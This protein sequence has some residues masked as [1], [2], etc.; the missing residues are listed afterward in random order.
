M[1]SPM[2]CFRSCISTKVLVILIMNP[3]PEKKILA[4]F[5]NVLSVY[6]PE[7]KKNLGLGFI[8]INQF[9]HVPTPNC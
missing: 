8:T 6:F 3:P 1:N 2:R 9:F 5:L 4:L 7:N